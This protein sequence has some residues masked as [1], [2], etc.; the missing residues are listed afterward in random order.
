M[1]DCVFGDGGRVNRLIG[2]E[3][4]GAGDGMRLPVTALE[5]LVGCRRNAMPGPITGRLDLKV[6][7][8]YLARPPGP[9]SR[10]ECVTHCD[11]C[12][13]PF[14]IYKIA[15]FLAICNEWS[16]TLPSPTTPTSHRRSSTMRYEDGS[17]KTQKAFV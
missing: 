15:S 4:A 2:W 5:T 17:V 6:G 10:K 1:S 8:R 9:Q 11:Q 13:R 7:H 12:D 16:K 3:E 14:F